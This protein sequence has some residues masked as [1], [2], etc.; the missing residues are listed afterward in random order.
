MQTSGSVGLTDLEIHSLTSSLH[1]LD[2]SELK[3]VKQATRTSTS[4]IKDIIYIHIYIY[5]VCTHSHTGQRKR[6]NT[7]RQHTYVCMRVLQAYIQCAGIPR[8][9]TSAHNIH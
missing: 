2:N 7:Y 8:V 4:E 1:S 3:Q 6:L 5:T 9:H